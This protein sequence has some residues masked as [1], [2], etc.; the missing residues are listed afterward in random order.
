MFRSL[1]RCQVTPQAVPEL[2]DALVLIWEE[3][4]QDTIR[5]LISEIL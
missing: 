3:A 2:S 4:P 1:Q 5:C